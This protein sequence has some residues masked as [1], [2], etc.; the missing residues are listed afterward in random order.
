MVGEGMGFKGNWLFGDREVKE[1]FLVRF[2]QAVPTELEANFWRVDS[3]GKWGPA[4]FVPSAIETEEV[5]S[6][7]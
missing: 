6:V 7:F 2:N 3:E 1:N 5:E 4:A